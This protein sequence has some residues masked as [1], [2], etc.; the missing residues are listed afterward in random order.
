M[1]GFLLSFLLSAVLVSALP[2][3]SHI[4]SDGTL[5]A[6]VLSSLA[7][8]I[9]EETYGRGDLRF[10]ASGYSESE[11]E[12]GFTEASMLLS[13]SGKE[14][15]LSFRGE[16]REALLE[17]LGE[18]T[19]SLL[20]YEPSLS[21]D[22][23][24]KLD[25]ITG[26]SYSFL[27]DRSFRRGTRFRA[28]DTEGRIR[29]IFELAEPFGEAKTLK[30]VYVNHPYP[31]MSLVP[32][33]NWKF[34]ASGAMGFR[35]NEFTASG[36]VSIG[37]TDLIY[38]FVPLISAAYVYDSGVHY[39]YG[40]IG[41]EAYLD[42][43]TIFPRVGFTLVQE[44]RIGGNASILLGGSS[45]GFDWSAVFSVFYEHNLSPSLHWRVGYQN[46]LGEHMLAIG[47]G[48]SF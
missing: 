22:G 23:E 43:A 11:E 33:G 24:M 4:V 1:R 48:G 3:V 27:T 40:G 31:G 32:G 6:D 2:A 28:M 45:S 18:E 36:I 20:F 46:L 14:I 30:P 15:L 5:P 9:G 47:F 19:R 26:G 38:P 21:S 44:G 13:F 29:G 12:N 35:F 37:R 34:T 42:L 41:I 25:Y 8:D 7:E 16:D 17:S 10:T 39:A